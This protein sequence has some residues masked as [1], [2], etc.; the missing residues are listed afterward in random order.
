MSNHCAKCQSTPYKACHFAYRF[1]V[2]NPARIQESIL[3][4]ILE[5]TQFPQV[6]IFHGHYNEP[7]SSEDKLRSSEIELR[8]QSWVDDGSVRA[9]RFL[10]T[11][12][13]ESK[14]IL[15]N[16]S[17]YCTKLYSENIWILEKNPLGESNWILA[18]GCKFLTV[19]FL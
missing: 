12:L 13:Q 7:Q 17:V 8:Q 6:A 4:K 18:L 5:L 9:K 11:K 2:R 1:R 19:M 10:S 16:I 3:A 15:V 14:W